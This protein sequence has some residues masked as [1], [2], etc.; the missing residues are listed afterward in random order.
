MPPNIILTVYL[1]Q[2]TS[3]VIQRMKSLCLDLVERT[4]YNVR[5]EDIC[6]N[7]ST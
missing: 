1:L 2:A 3:G 7:D 5:H 6:S 4:Y